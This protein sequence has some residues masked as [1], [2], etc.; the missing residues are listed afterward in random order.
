MPGSN[1]LVT[2]GTPS[3]GVVGATEGTD[4]AGG[5]RPGAV[6]SVLSAG[7]HQARV[8]TAGGVRPGAV[9]S[10]LTPGVIRSVVRPTGSS[11]D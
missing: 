4:T 1:G 10:V 7:R 8:V 11:G 5:V 9:R 3:A 2:D 6:R